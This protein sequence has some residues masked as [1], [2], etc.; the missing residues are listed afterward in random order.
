MIKQLWEDDSPCYGINRIRFLCGNVIDAL[1]TLP[2]ESVHCVVTSPPYFRLRRYSNA[3][4]FKNDVPEEM[5]VKI[6]QE[7]SKR[8]IVPIEKA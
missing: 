8:G 5:R 2:D 3:V 1:K 7:L 6:I 4:K